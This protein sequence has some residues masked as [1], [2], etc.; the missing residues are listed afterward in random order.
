MD[1]CVCVSVSA[2]YLY[3]PGA[4]NA[5]EEVRHPHGQHHRLSEQLLS[6]LQISDVFPGSHTHIHT[7]TNIVVDDRHS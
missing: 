3:L 1:A 4:T 5:L 2:S 7:H 6:I